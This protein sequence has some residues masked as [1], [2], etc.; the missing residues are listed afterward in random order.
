MTFSLICF[1]PGIFLPMLSLNLQANIEAQF[2]RKSLEL[3]NAEH[4]IL[5]TLKQLWSHGGYAAAFLIFLLSIV[6]PIIKSILFM[7]C[8]LKTNLNETIRNKLINI[9]AFISKWSF[10]DVL[11]IAILIAFLTAARDPEKIN[12]VVKFMGMQIPIGVTLPLK[13]NFGMGFY[14]FTAFCLFSNL[15][16]SVYMFQLKK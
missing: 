12:E 1:I 11:T 14:F 4:S 10:A 7:F 6:N 8:L 5:S 13:A 3:L 9:L 16:I 2:L 15:S